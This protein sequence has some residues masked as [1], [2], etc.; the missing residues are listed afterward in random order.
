MNTEDRY[1]NIIS[2]SR[3]R[4]EWDFGVRATIT[5]LSFEEMNELRQMIIVAIGVAEDMW[6]RGR[7]ESDEIGSK[8]K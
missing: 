6:K 7:H 3:K 5:E 1:E 8:P 4:G 2:L